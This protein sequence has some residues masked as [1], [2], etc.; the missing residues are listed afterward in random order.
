MTQ[1]KDLA[2]HSRIFGL[3]KFSMIITSVV[4]IL[5][6]LGSLYVYTSKTESLVERMD[7]IDK[8]G[9]VLD[10]TSGIMMGAERRIMDYQDRKNQLEGLIRTTV[11]CWFTLNGD[12]FKHQIEK[13]LDLSSPKLA[14]KM[15]D[16]YER[17]Q[18]DWNL[19]EYMQGTNLRWVV[20]EDSIHYNMESHVGMFYG[21]KK[22]LK[23][24]NAIWTKL[25]IKYQINETLKSTK[26]NLYAAVV[27]DW[28]IMD[29]TQL[30]NYER[31]R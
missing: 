4:L 18:G 27:D 23:G 21:K 9:W 12:I 3:A 5:G 22:I 17:Y 14:N 8:K 25:V 31:I 24:K 2:S 15:F 16:K 26:K 11:G 28:I 6:T 1:F 30:K 29:E 10:P 7:D 20:Y 13:G 19:G